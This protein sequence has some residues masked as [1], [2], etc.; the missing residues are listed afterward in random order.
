MPKKNYYELFKL[1]PPID[2]VHLQDAY[3]QLIFEY[4]PDRNP[5]RQEWAIERTMEIVEAYNTLVDPLKRDVYNF[6]IRNDIRRE[7]GENYGVKKPLL[8]LGKSKEEIQGEAHFRKGVDF[9]ADR[10]T[11]NQAVHEWNQALKLLP[12]LANAY[13]NMGILFGYQGNFKD[14]MAALDQALKLNPTD[15]DFMKAKSMVMSYVYGK[16]AE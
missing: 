2:P 12:G 9:F 4:H 1:Y 6:E 11:W 8:K 7:P 15:A 10:D 16:K 14:A 13:F 5:D 3:K